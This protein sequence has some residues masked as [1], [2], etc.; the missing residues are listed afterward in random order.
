MTDIYV[1]LTVAV[2]TS[3]LTNYIQ[4]HFYEKS[5]KRKEALNLLNEYYAQLF[6]HYTIY[7]ET[8]SAAA[9]GKL[10]ASIEKA[11]IVAPNPTEKLLNDFETKVLKNHPDNELAPIVSALRKIFREDIQ[12]ILKNQ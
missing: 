4:H 3:F 9:K 8:H 10:L 2:I 12:H 6:T 1:A 7:L 5:E 11:R